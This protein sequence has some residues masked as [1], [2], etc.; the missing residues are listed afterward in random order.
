MHFRLF[1]TIQYRVVIIN[2]NLVQF[3]ARV[4][5]INGKTSYVYNLEGNT[6]SNI[7]ILK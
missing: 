7:N 2:M 5:A 6:L 3:L 1:Q 4:G